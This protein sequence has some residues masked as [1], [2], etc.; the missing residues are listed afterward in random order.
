MKSNL[1]E[2]G[3]DINDNTLLHHIQKVNRNSFLPQFI[4][5][6]PDRLQQVIINLI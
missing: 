6:D 2:H 4:N 3:R 1:A 5:G